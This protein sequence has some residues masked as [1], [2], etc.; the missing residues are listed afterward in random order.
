MRDV[1]LWIRKWEKVGR[2]FGTYQ[3]TLDAK[4]RLQIPTKLVKDMPSR[5]YLLRGNERSLSL[6]LEE[7][8]NL[9][10]TTLS[11]LSYLDSNARA[12]VRLASSSVEILEVDSHGRI[13]IGS[14]IAKR[15]SIS[16]EVTIIGVLD[17]FEIW[18][19]KSYEE[20]LKANEASFES[21]AEDLSKLSSEDK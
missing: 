18:D 9:Y 2:F 15:Y 3:R 7:D 5:F 14:E 16:N 11:K 10:L 4:L 13:N 6:Y 21:I 8:F 20:Y 1:R 19:K 17:H 12:Y